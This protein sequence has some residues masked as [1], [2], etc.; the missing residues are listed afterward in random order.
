MGEGIPRVRQKIA[1]IGIKQDTQS[2]HLG[3]PT[4]RLQTNNVPLLPHRWM[5]SRKMQEL[6]TEE[7]TLD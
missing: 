4:Q 7:N 6:K 2:K 1:A 5:Y 3:E